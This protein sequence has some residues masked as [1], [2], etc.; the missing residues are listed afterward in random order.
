MDEVRP[1]ALVPTRQGKDIGLFPLYEHDAVVRVGPMLHALGVTKPTIGHPHRGG[2][3][4][5][6]PTKRRHTL[7]E[8]AL[9]PAEFVPARGS[10][11]ARVGPSH[12]TIHRNDQLAIAN[13]H[14][15]EEPI[16]PREHAMLLT[17]PPAAHEAPLLAILVKDGIIE[18]P[19]PLP[20]A[21]RGRPFRSDLAPQRGQH[22][23][24]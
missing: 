5:P 24:A 14:H 4:H 17:T 3:P 16:N 15:K 8:H 12:R 13:A 21:L 6:T 7:V 10:G 22:L 19:R 9:R 1:F 2:Q 23:P 18:H 20:A 11:T